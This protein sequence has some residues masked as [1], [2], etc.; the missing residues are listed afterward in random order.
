MYQGLH[1]NLPKEI[2]HYPD[3]PFPDSIN[4]YISANEVLKYYESYAE[5]FDLKKFIKFEHY[6]LRVRPVVT[7][8]SN[9]E[10]WEVTVKNL[11]AEKYETYYFDAVIVGSGHYNSPHIPKYKNLESFKVKNF[12]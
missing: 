12:S 7:D 10:K 11:P 9:N 3:F 4:S 2:M 8:G 5:F 1:T 6:V